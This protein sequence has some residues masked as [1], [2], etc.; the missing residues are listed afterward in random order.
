MRLRSY[1]TVKRLLW[2]SVGLSVFVG[3]VFVL[4]SCTS[5]APRMQAVHSRIMVLVLAL[6]IVLVS[7]ASACS[8]V[9]GS[10]IANQ[11]VSRGRRWLVRISF[12]GLFLV[13]PMLLSFGHFFYIK[14]KAHESDTAQITLV[15][16]C[17][18]NS[19]MPLHTTCDILGV[20]SVGGW[21]LWA[22]CVLVA[23]STQAV[24]AAY[25]CVKSG[26]ASK[27]KRTLIT[28]VNR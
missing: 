5:V 28:T 27:V 18:R 9:A 23:K 3:I 25:K 22:W 26:Q 7:F 17:S 12:Y 6:F 10:L 21:L 4:L 15:G 24:I 8:G 20:I 11:V 19:Y 16:D 14:A 1:R 2:S 13:G